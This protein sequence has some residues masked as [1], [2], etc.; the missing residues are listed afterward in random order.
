MWSE[1]SAR[2]SRRPSSALKYS[3]IIEALAWPVLSSRVPSAQRRVST[4]SDSAHPACASLVRCPSRAPSKSPV[5]HD[6]G[7]S[8]WM[9]QGSFVL[10]SASWASPS[11]ASHAVAPHAATSTTTRRTKMGQVLRP[12]TPQT[13]NRQ[14]RRRVSRVVITPSVKHRRSS[15]STTRSPEGRSG[16]RQRCDGGWSPARPALG[17]RRD[18]AGQLSDRGG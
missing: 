17:V 18:R 14:Q 4:I 13:R 8:H 2:W 11:S 15:R 7:G 6:C 10:A 16:E 9:R 3:V 1:V 12:C 5:E